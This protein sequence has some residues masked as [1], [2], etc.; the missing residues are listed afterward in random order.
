MKLGKYKMSGNRGLF[1][2]QEIKEKLREIGNPLE[3]TIEVVD[4]EMFR[5]LI[6]VE[7]LNHTKKNNAGAKPFDV[8]MMFK[9]LILQR[10][11]GLGDSQIEY[12]IKDRISFKSFLGLSSGD[13]VPDEKTVWEFR[14]FITNKGVIERLF[15]EFTDF[16]ES[17]GLL[18][19]EGKMIDAGFTV[20][21]S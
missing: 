5:S 7:M 3:K 6:E 16:L 19:N 14:E 10:Y 20:A 8:V 2:E 12:Q 15:A 18:M 9:I 13:K 11:Y 1:D 17:K 21:P 4:F